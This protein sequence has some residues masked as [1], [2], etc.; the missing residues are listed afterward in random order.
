MDITETAL[1]ASIEDTEEALRQ[2]LGTKN[3]PDTP[4]FGGVGSYVAQGGAIVAISG[5]IYRTFEETVG[6]AI[7]VAGYF[8]LH[9]VSKGISARTGDLLRE[10][11]RLAAEAGGAGGC[12]KSAATCKRLLLSLATL[13]RAE[14]MGRLVRVS[15]WLYGGVAL[16]ALAEL[17]KRIFALVS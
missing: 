2:R 10:A 12:E 11:E 15:A 13:R 5:A 9:S 4:F 14:T 1:C 3:V 8:A 6:A 17:T 7:L 16:L